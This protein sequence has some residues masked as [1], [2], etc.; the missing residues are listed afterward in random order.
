MIGTRVARSPLAVRWDRAGRSQLA[1]RT[2]LAIG[3]LLFQFVPRPGAHALQGQ[4]DWSQ[5]ISPGGSVAIWAYGVSRSEAQ[6]YL[7][8]LGLTAGAVADPRVDVQGSD[9][10]HGAQE[11]TADW[12]VTRLELNGRFAL[13]QF[14]EV[15]DHA[16]TV[17]S[18]ISSDGLLT[19]DDRG[20]SRVSA[21]R[22]FP[23]ATCY[24]GPDG[25]DC[26][27]RVSF[28]A[29]SDG[30]G[31]I[32]EFVRD[33]EGFPRAVRFSETLLFRY[34][35]TPPLP[36]PPTLALSDRWREPSS[37]DLIDLRTSEMV[38]DSVDAA[39][40][41][42]DRPVLSVILR[43][44][45]EVLRFEDGQPFAVAQGIRQSPH[46]LLPIK[47]T[48]EVWRSVYVNGD[49]SPQYRFRVDYTDRLVRVEIGGGRLGQSI[50]V[51]APRS[52]DSSAPV[53]FVHPRAEMLTDAMRSG[54]RLRITEPLDLWLHD[55]LEKERLPI[56][57]RPL[58]H[59]GIET[60]MGVVHEAART[61]QYFP[62]GPA[63]GC[64]VEADRVLCTGGASDVIGEESADPW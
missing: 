8:R 20:G 11:A 7:E 36:E 42:S 6:E 47:G 24:R 44:I 13:R 35:F 52:L 32:V 5:E 3:V 27:E 29:A 22:K 39:K 41:A 51:E 14:T 59:T 61:G 38:I 15:L 25:G 34:S 23:L 60:E 46:A 40:V 4:P 28:D 45:G 17:T 2:L 54:A 12:A 50:V 48:S 1:R 16:M 62:F 18:I 58:R 33:H 9:A 31:L 19:T 63:D 30:S 55:A 56:V 64:E 43:G 21:Y 37:W 49:G 26:A 57:L 53:S 10:F